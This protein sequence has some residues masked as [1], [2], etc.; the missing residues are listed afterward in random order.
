MNS[1]R[2]TKIVILGANGQ[3][4]SD[5][6]ISASSISDNVFNLTHDDVDVENI[7]SV[8]KVLNDINP[9]IVLNT[10]A[11]HN[12]PKCEERPDEAFQVNAIGALNIAKITQELGATN[13][14]FST[15]YVFD[16]KK[17]SPYIEEDIP[18]PLNVYAVSKLSGENFTLNYSHKAFVFRISGIYGSVPCR[19]KGG[20]FI[21]TMLKL[22]SERDEVSVVT[23]EVLSPTSTKEISDHAIKFIFSDAAGLYHFTS[24]G[25]CS[26]YDFAEEIFKV[27]RIKT[28]IRK[29]T[30]KDFP[31]SVDRPLYSV[32]ENKNYNNLGTV[33]FS[34]WRDSLHIFLQEKYL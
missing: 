33:H 11:F 22:S 8:S 20:N 4:G 21:T 32:L 10:A 9:D 1:E 34:H 25:S 2:N 19:A 15:D 16:G 14:Y 3:L 12:V 5:L 7:D 28:P 24:E 27:L 30:S 31:S 17:K 18:N 23:D 6:S 29:A 26:W 13:V